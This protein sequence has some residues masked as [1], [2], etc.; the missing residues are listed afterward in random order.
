MHVY[1]AEH[2][3]LSVLYSGRTLR[4]GRAC[5][6]LGIGRMLL[7]V[8]SMH[9]WGFMPLGHM[10]SLGEILPLAMCCSETFLAFCGEIDF[11]LTPNCLQ[12]HWHP[13]LLPQV[14]KLDNRESIFKFPTRRQR[15]NAKK[16]QL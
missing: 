6:R 12:S 2:L 14:S 1:T 3:R 11:R 8:G 16:R 7:G 5:A 13:F 15:Q 10:G 4:C 9:V